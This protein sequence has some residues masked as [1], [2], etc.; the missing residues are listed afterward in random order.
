[1]SLI[2]YRVRVL[3]ETSGTEAKV[4][5]LIESRDKECVWRTVGVSHDILEASLQA[6]L[7]SIVYKLFLD[8]HREKC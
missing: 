7:D 5:V 1:M 2:D 3:P 4:R 6:L 8:E